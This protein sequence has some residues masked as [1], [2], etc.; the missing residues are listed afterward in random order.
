MCLRFIEA[1]RAWHIRSL[2]SYCAKFPNFDLTSNRSTRTK[3][4]WNICFVNLTFPIVSRHICSELHC[5]CLS[6][7]VCTYIYIKLIYVFIQLREISSW[8]CLYEWTGIWLTTLAFQAT[9]LSPY[10]RFRFSRHLS[11][12]HESRSLEQQIV[13]DAHLSVGRSSSLVEA[14][15]MNSVEGAS[16]FRRWEQMKQR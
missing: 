6:G 8:T 2:R 9:L 13:F 7:Y 10:F 5:K 15:K 16:F 14:T 4:F 3:G 1:I 11:D 12:A